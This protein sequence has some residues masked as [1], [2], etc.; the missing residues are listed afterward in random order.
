MVSKLR[1]IVLMSLFGV[2]I[3]MPKV[4]LPT[5]LDKILF[6]VQALVLG[7]G[8]LL[9]GKL[10][11]T[12]TAFIGGLLTTILRPAFFPLSLLFA[13]LYGMLIDMFFMVFRV[14]T[15]STLRNSRIIISTTLSTIFTG[16]VSY[17]ITAHLLGLLPRNIL[18]EITI[19]VAGTATGA[20][21]GWLITYLWKKGIQNY[22]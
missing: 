17:Y 16:L 19:L 1:R 10:G 8:A 22:V 20:V 11:A 9:L 15:A 4:M 18:I 7:L 2:L 13:V 3:F 5:P 6:L 12:Y 21:G 14:K